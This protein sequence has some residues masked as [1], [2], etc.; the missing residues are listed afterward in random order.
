MEEIWVPIEGYEDSYHVSNLG[1]IKSF[2]NGKETILKLSTN[3]NGYKVFYLNKPKTKRKLI[4]V[5]RLVAKY[6]IPNPENKPYVN[7]IDYNPSNN[8][9]TN[10]EWVTPKE[11]SIWSA[12]RMPK[13]Y[14]NISKLTN[15]KYIT[16]GHNKYIVNINKLN[17]NKTFATLT[18][19]IEFRDYVL[20]NNIVKP[21]TE[22][23]YKDILSKTG[24]K[25]ITFE[26]NRYR[27]RIFF[28]NY[29]KSFYSLEEAVKARQNL[30]K[31]EEI[32][33]GFSN[34]SWKNE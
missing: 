11:N 29:N 27:L 26:N 15:E 21:K 9:V 33:R 16:Y 19:A 4:K 25:Y 30:L 8:V 10:L 1:R 20:L 6:F 2:K 23:V 5:H 32:Y 13:E 22:R 28:L 12:H 18:E 31:N 24:E 3:E 14:N 17:Q 34:G 7:H